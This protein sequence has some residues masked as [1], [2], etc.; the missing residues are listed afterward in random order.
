MTART[1]PCFA[2][3][4]MLLLTAGSLAAQAVSNFDQFFRDKTMRV[5]YFHTAGKS[6]DEI[7]ALDD[8]VSD[9]PWAGS[10]SR[11]LDETNLGDFFF[12]V[13]DRDTNRQL[14]SRGFSSIFGEWITTPESKTAYRNFHE[15]LRFPWPKK[16]VH[17]VLQRRNEDGAGFHEVWDTVIDPDSRFVNSADS[18]KSA[19]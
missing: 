14:Y 17:V 10:H 11:L 6:G 18:E 4:A 3:A 19:P 13:L 1:H 12:V 2:V 16:P 15:S 7:V 9:G 5:D 8:V